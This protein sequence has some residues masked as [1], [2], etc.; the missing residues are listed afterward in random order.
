MKIIEN[1]AA[2]QDEPPIRID[3]GDILHWSHIL[4]ISHERLREIIAAVGSTI[5]AVYAEV[6]RL[7]VN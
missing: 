2:A 7:Q 1:P 4:G 5:D 6:R 3:C